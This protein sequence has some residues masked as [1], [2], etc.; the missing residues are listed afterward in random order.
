MFNLG[1]KI[2]N[3]RKENNI[4]QEELAN[5]LN[6]SRQS[7]SKWESGLSLP[8]I[9]NL[10]LISE[11]FNCTIDSLLLEET[12]S[13]EIPNESFATFGERLIYLRK[14]NHMSQ[15]LLSDAL[16]VS[17]QSIFKYERN[18]IYPDLDKIIKISNLYNCSID[19]LLKEKEN[20]NEQFIEEKKKN[21]QLDFLD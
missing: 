10:L 13:L 9:S 2:V 7:I 14:K 12:T 15:E 21:N 1:E 17:R 4:T 8:E 18:L 6:V 5:K 20:I 19:Y 16:G 11:I 3:L